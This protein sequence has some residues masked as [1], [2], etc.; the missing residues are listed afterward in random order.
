MAGDRKEYMSEPQQLCLL[1]NNEIKHPRRPVE[2]VAPPNE[3]IEKFANT[4]CR[5]LGE[6]HG[7]DYSD[8]AT[9]QG[10]TSFLKT[11]V[12]IKVK[13]MNAGANHVQEK[14]NI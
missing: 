8:T 12:S 5:K 10:F 13:A 9:V 4:F 2:Y 3:E 14:N 1:P 7:T 11:V 6:R